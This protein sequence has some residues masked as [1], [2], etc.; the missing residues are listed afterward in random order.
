MPVKSR[1]SPQSNSSPA[2]KDDIAITELPLSHPS[3]TRDP[4]VPTLID[5]VDRKRPRDSSGNPILPSSPGS[6]AEAQEE[7]VVGPVATAVF[8]AVPLTF[9]LAA[10]EIV[11]HQQYRQELVIQE[12]VLKSI[13]AFPILFTLV[14]FTHPHRT[15]LP[16][17]L[18]LCA[19]SIGAG[20]WLVHAAN[21][22]NYYAV[23][24]RAPPVGTLWIWSAVE[25]DLGWLVLSCL[26]VAGWTWW[27]GFSIV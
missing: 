14:Y 10:F 13:K 9:L 22:L 16:L 24:K 21:K 11:V 4:S 7:E 8:F 19:F 26:A 1:K 18:I 15:R 25:M 5:L 12:V 2:K 27:K 6:D 20:C 3:R 23:M 17:Q